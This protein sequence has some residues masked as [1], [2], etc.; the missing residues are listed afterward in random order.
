M[1][2]APRS[3]RNS[4]LKMLCDQGTPRKIIYGDIHER[5]FINKLLYKPISY[6]Q[7]GNKLFS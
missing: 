7:P 5:V 4:M 1:Y 2:E 3:I 6:Q